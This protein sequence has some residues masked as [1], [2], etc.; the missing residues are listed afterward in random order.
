MG[1]KRLAAL[2]ETALVLKGGLGKKARATVS[3]AITNRPPD[4]GGG[5]RVGG[6]RPARW[7]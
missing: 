3:D 6:C 2:G 5:R 4:V 1:L 7:R